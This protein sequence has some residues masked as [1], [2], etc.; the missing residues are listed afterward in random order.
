MFKD[1]PILNVYYME[2]TRENIPLNTELTLHKRKIC[3]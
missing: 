3:V 2:N 1:I